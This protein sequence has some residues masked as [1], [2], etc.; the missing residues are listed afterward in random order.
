[1]GTP[2]RKADIAYGPRSVLIYA[3][4]ASIDLVSQRSLRF[5]ADR[6]ARKQMAQIDVVS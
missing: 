2:D 3:S 5:D 1:M 6:T 4:A